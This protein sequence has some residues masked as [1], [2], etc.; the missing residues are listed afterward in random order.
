MALNWLIKN[1]SNFKEEARNLIFI[2]A[3]DIHF[4]D[5][6]VFL[7]ILGHFTRRLFLSQK[8][9]QIRSNQIVEKEEKGR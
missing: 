7:S 3:G 2:L 8:K 4:K 9:T 6:S 1:R 5:A